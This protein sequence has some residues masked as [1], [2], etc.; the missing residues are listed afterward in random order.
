MKEVIYVRSEIQNSPP[1]LEFEKHC[2]NIM[3]ER[4]KRLSL[5]NQIMFPSLRKAEISDYENWLSGY[6]ANGGEVSHYY[7]YPFQ[8]WDNFY[9][10]TQDFEVCPLYGSASILI[11]VPKG[12][13]YLGG[14]IGHSTLYLCDGYK[15]KYNDFVPAFCNT[16]PKKMYN[17]KV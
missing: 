1:R 5:A 9:V 10:A 7:D 14:N 4:N 12:I 13:K 11:I 17:Q 16:N 8:R 6:F 15:T 3:S 2:R